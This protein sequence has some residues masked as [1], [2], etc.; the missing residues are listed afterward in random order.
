MSENKNNPNG[1]LSL[2][3]SFIEW[4]NAMQ[5]YNH[6]KLRKVASDRKQPNLR[7]AAGKQLLQIT[8]PT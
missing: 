8:R 2:G 5:R 1:R 7:R 3:L 6:A 4:L